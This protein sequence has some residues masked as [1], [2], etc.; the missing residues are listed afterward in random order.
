MLHGDR[1]RLGRLDSCDGRN[2]ILLRYL[3]SSP[4]SNCGSLEDTPHQMCASKRQKKYSDILSTAVDNFC[5]S[6]RCWKTK[7]KTNF[8]QCNPTLDVTNV[9]AQHFFKPCFSRTCNIC[10]QSYC[11]ATVSQ[12]CFKFRTHFHTRL[13]SQMFLYIV[14]YTCCFINTI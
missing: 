9:N 5:A 12:Y 2:Q 8:K 14:P 13:F 3:V 6:C 4:Q 1:T 10:H 11:R 7:I